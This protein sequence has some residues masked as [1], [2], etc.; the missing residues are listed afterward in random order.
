MGVDMPPKGSAEAYKQVRT[1]TMML[2]KLDPQSQ[3]VNVISIPRDSKV[4]IAG[5]QGVNKINAALPL[6]G[7]D[8]AVTTVQQTLGVDVN[9]YLIINL[10]GVHEVVDAV[11]GIDIYVEKPMHYHDHTAHLNIDFQPGEHHLDGQQAEEYLRFRHDAYGDIGRIRRQQLFIAAFTAKLKDPSI[12]LKLKPLIDASNKYVETNLSTQ[13][14]L[15]MALFAKGLNK[16]NYQTA[17]LPGHPSSS[18]AVSYWIIDSK[19]A[20]DMVNRM[21][22]GIDGAADGSGEAGTPAG[23]QT[24]GLL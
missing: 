20:E 7:P 10:R 5:N 9:N 4:Y 1:D 13:D 14:L 11:G 8:T 18:S 17:T 23:A 6:G 24:V 16:S 15:S 2:V 12:I 22:V 3:K 19:P 21:I